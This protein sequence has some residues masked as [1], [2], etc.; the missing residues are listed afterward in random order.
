M[1]NTVYFDPAVGGNGLTVTDD[2]NPTTGLDNDGHRA[3]FV[4][5]L[6]Q[7]VAV[8]S[9]VVDTAQDV[10]DDATT[11]STAAITATAQAGIAT[12]KAGE[13]ATSATNAANSATAASTSATNSANSAT[14]AGNSA[15]SAAASAS[16]ATTKASEASVSATSASNSATSANNSAIAAGV[17]AANA[18]NSAT[19][20]SNSA[21]TA[22]T[23]A[24][25][26]TTKAGEASASALAASNS[27]TAASNSADEAEY[28]AGQAG[29]T[30]T[31]GVKVSGTDTT[32][33][34]LDAKIVAGNNITLTKL[35]AGGNEQY[36]VTNSA[37]GDLVTQTT[38]NAFL[39]S[40][41]FIDIGSIPAN[42]WPVLVSTATTVTIDDS[43]K[44]FVVSGTTTV[45]LPLAADVFGRE[46]PFSVNV[47]A[48]TGATVTVARSGTDTI[49]TVAGN[50]TMSAN[51]A[52]TFYPISLTE[53]ETR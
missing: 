44:T 31:G 10:N 32:A 36:Q 20:A 26:A 19:A 17:S 39:G 5:A 24:G 8:A 13:A 50:K 34:T 51:T 9:H 35:N 40:S 33:G 42:V 43:A 11:A 47:K 49:E 21:T 38:A 30:A 52:L 29:A 45:T 6:S 37:L 16:T 22:T 15:T 12:N 7:V 46:I 53:W 25:I 48:R 18:A 4:P 1:T 2:G 3:R 14:S 41:A 23:Q 27:A 28:W